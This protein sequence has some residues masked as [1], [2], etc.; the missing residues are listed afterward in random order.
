MNAC[1]PEDLS[2]YTN[3]SYEPADLMSPVTVVGDADESSTA[4]TL[5]LESSHGMPWVGPDPLD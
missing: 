2:A 1:P 5:P 3:V 4:P